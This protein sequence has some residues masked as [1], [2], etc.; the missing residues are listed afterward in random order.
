MQSPECPL[1]TFLFHDFVFLTK[2]GGGDEDCLYLAVHVAVL[3]GGPCVPFSKLRS[4]SCD[5]KIAKTTISRLKPRTPPCHG[6]ADWR[7]LSRRWGQLVRIY[8]LIFTSLEQNFC[9][10]FSFL[11]FHKKDIIQI[12]D[13]HH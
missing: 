8:A 7:C 9:F 6:L 13:G 4:Q 2:V 10:Y 3:E 1:P 5:Q 11:Q 12:I